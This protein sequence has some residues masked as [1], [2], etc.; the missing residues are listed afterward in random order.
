MSSGSRVIDTILDTAKRAG[1]DPALWA[2]LDLTLDEA[3]WTVDLLD[4]LGAELNTLEG[5]NPERAMKLGVLLADAVNRRQ[6]AVIVEQL[7]DDVA[8]TVT[9]PPLRRRRPTR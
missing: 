9:R 2:T 1:G 5:V 4:Y 8:H 7:V 6:Q 3:G